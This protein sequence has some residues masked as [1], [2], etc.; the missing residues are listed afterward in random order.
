MT[1]EERKQRARELFRSGYN[2]C[3]A[4]AMT[5]ADV[6]G[7]PEDEI[8]RL[9]SGFGGGMG[10]MREVCGT[11]SGMVI[12]SGAIIPATD[13]TDRGRPRLPIML[14]FRRW[15]VNSVRRTAV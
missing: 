3:Q 4:V 2:C 6:I 7:L 8:A 11:V 12:V 14:W 5:F 1:V 15:R 13:V 10:R 9:A